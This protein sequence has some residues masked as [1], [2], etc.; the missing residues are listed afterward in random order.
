MAVMCSTHC[1]EEAGAVSQLIIYHPSPI[2]SPLVIARLLCSLFAR[3]C[4]EVESGAVEVVV[5]GRQ[6]NH[7]SKH[8]CADTVQWKW[9][10][11]AISRA[12]GP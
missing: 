7:G 11:M 10:S 1:G 3:M 4:V 12:T 2:T 9:L 5:D 8:G 6:Q